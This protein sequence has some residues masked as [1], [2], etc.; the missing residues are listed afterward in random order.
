MERAARVVDREKQ[1]E[2]EAGVKDTAKEEAC[3]AAR[4]EC[5]NNC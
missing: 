2:L 1:G 4:D 5:V 3:Q